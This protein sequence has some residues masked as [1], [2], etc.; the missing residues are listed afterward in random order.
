[1]YRVGVL[2]RM[3]RERERPGR[4]LRLKTIR[5]PGRRHVMIY[6]DNDVSEW[7]EVPPAH[8]LCHQSLFLAPFEG[9]AT[10]RVFI[11]K[12]EVPR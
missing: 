12:H 11:H 3:D 5:L 4:F 10:N 7:R 2:N 8:I 1:M 9:I 6:F